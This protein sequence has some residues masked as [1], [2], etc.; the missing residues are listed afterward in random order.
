MKNESNPPTEVRSSDWL[1]LIPKRTCLT[2]PQDLREY[3][4]DADKHG[5]H[6]V[7]IHPNTC[8]ALAAEIERLRGTSDVLRRW[9][10]EAL[11]VMDSIDPDDSED[12]GDALRMLMDRGQRLVEV[13]ASRERGCEHEWVYAKNKAVV[14]GELCIKCFT[15]RA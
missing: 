11:L 1:G 2:T 10:L 13:L 7:P 14:S 9:M 8:R 12:G 5:A 3:A 4:D 6:W 15:L